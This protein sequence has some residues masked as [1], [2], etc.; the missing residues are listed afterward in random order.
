MNLIK[1]RSFHLDG[2]TVELSS[3]SNVKTQHHL[4]ERLSNLSDD[5]PLY[6][7]VASDDDYAALTPL[8]QTA[9]T[10]VGQPQVT[11]IHKKPFKINSIGWMVASRNPSHLLSNKRILFELYDLPPYK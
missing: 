4:L 11:F 5:E 8:N 3:I 10:A 6:D 1:S 2:P 7:A 9:P